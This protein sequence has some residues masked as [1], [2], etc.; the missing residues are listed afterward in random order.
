VLVDDLLLGRV[1]QEGA[2]AAD[3]GEIE[4]VEFL[5][6]AFHHLIGDVGRVVK[7]S[8]PA[9]QPPRDHAMDLGITIFEQ[10]PPGR[11]I[12]VAGAHQQV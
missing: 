11:L 6:Q 10:F 4:A 3:R 2:E 9:G 1:D 8:H 5:G 12:A 7:P